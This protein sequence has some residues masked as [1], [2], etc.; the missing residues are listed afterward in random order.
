VQVA[1]AV[2]GKL[3][4]SEGFGY[5]D[6]EA[7]A[8]RHAR[9][10]VSDRERIEAAHG[11]R[12][13]PVVRAGTLDLDAP[14]QRYVRRSRT[15]A[16]H[17]HPAARGHLAGSGITKDQEFVSN[18]HYASVLDGLKI[19]QDDSL[20]FPPRHAF[21]VYEHGWNLVSAVVEGRRET[22]SCTTSRR[23]MFRPLV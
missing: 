5:A 22:T 9:D 12:R 15:R 16:T 2:N 19:F 10:A 13:P 11:H 17:Q 1:V 4:W 3:V 7:P 14:V 8:A 21:L 6:A 18:R 20:L 23:T